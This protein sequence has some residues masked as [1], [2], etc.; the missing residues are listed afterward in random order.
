MAEDDQEKTEA[1]T[2]RRREEARDNGQVARSADLTSAALL[3]GI[4]LIMNSFGGELIKSLSLLMAKLLS[5]ESMLNLDPAALRT[6]LAA[7]L[8]AVAQAAAPLLLG[9]LVITVIANLLQVGIFFNPQRLAPNFGALNPLKNLGRLL[10]GEGL[11]HLLMNLFKI[12]LVGALAWSAVTGRMGT[13]IGSQMLD[14]HQAFGLGS[15]L[16]FSVGLRIALALFVLALI[17]Y[18]VQRYRHE[19]DLRMS[20]QEIKEE[21]RRM[22]GDPRLKQRRR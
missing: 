18:A 14:S 13:I 7:P 11:V 3:L 21:M 19:R 17:D 16:I 6:D 9:G 2:A 10:K 1:P 12:S 15:S 20:K 22:E 5:N 8:I 4:L